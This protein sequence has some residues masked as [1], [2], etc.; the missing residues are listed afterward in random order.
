MIISATYETGLL[1]VGKVGERVMKTDMTVTKNFLVM[2]SHQLLYLQNI[3]EVKLCRRLNMKALQAQE[4]PASSQG[5]R[6][7]QARRVLRIT[8]KQQP[9][10]E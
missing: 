10:A 8:L 3:F 7:A 1:L 6:G 4:H 5:S 2:V 9:E